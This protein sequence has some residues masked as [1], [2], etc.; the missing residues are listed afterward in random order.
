MALYM[1]VHNMDGTVKLADVAN[2]HAADLSKQDA[3][4]VHYLR[5][6]VSEDEGKIFCL[7]DAPSVEAA[8][9]V[10]RE[11]HGLVADDVFLVAEGV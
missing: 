8:N 7:V 3:H 6:W 5:Y 4:G 11:A 10:H 9:T 2:A 1:D